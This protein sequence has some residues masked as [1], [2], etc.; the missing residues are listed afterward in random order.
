[1]KKLIA[2]M[3]MAGIVAASSSVFA[4]DAVKTEGTK[5]KTLV[6]KT[7]ETKKAESKPA[8]AKKAESKPADSKKK[9]KTK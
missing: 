6:A 2:M 9:E 8:E 1:M 3:V 5:D 7:T 4:A